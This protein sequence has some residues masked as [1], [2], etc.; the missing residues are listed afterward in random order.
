MSNHNGPYRRTNATHAPGD[1]L[2]DDFL[3]RSVT[4]TLTNSDSVSPVT[5]ALFGTPLPRHREFDESPW[6]YRSAQLAHFYSQRRFHMVALLLAVCALTLFY[7]Y[8]VIPSGHA[9]GIQVAPAPPSRYSRATT[10]AWRALNVSDFVVIASPC[11]ANLAVSR[12]VDVEAIHR[13]PKSDDAMLLFELLLHSESIWASRSAESLPC[14]CAPQL[15]ISARVILYRDNND[16]TQTLLNPRVVA[17]VSTSREIVRH[18]QTATV[19]VPDSY[20]P[21]INGTHD[22]LLLRGDPLVIEHDVDGGT[23]RTTFSS[24]LAYCVEECV[25]LLDGKTIWTKAL[26]QM[27]DGVDVNRA[28]AKELKQYQC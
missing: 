28:W 2:F 27:R 13:F 17:D 18:S 10:A 1:S 9:I 15:N 12:D 25:D 7:L 19:N 24:G 16:D 26:E 22:V 8:W 5:K 23:R 21:T 6:R 14:F 4:P 11:R 3:A 20:R